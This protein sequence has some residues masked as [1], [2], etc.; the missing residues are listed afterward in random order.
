MDGHDPDAVVAL[1]RGRGLGVGVGLGAGG[2]EVEEAAQVA[3][4]GASNS[5]A[6]RISLRTLAKRA[7]PAG[8]IRIARS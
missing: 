4:L 6:S 7:S 3:T 5:A 2:E 8:R 1:G